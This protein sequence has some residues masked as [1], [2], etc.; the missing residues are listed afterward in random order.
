M[1]AFSTDNLPPSER[2]DAFHE[3]ITRLSKTE[4][5]RLDELAA[6]PFRGSVS[7]TPLGHISFSTLAGTPTRYWCL[8]G[9]ERFRP[10]YL[11]LMVNR[12]GPA[13][14]SQYDQ[15]AN[16]TQTGATIFD[17]RACGATHYADTYLTYAYNVP[18]SLMLAAA[19]NA[20]TYSARPVQANPRILGYLISYTD[21]VLASGDLRDP[22]LAA[23]IGNH[24][25]DLVAALLGPSREAAETASKRG[26]RTTRLKAILTEI[27]RHFSDPNLSAQTIAARYGLS[28]RNVERLMEENGETVSRAVL[29]R[30]L[31]AAAAMLSDPRT[32]DMRISE[33]A[34][35]CGFSELSHFNR[36]FKREYG[37]APR[38]FRK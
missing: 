4:T 6:Q 16:F 19:P 12:A 23:N 7:V 13:I 33:I 24:M 20:D 38:L 11:R 3:F 17:N 2:F 8:P 27:D 30:R 31:A 15:N 32:R 36:S 37:E 9:S 21:A 35:A 1:I 25:F 22:V 5:Q 34:Y 18:R 29:R 10:D 28:R 26:L 14:V